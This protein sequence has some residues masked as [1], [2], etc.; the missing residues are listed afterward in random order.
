MKYKQFLFISILNLFS[1][2]LSDAQVI[3]PGLDAVVTLYGQSDGINPGTVAY[4]KSVGNQ[5]GAPHHANWVPPVITPPITNWTVD[6]LGQVFGIAIDDVGNVY[7]STTAMYWGGS[8]NA[9]RLATATPSASGA[10]GN[11]YH[12][13]GGAAG[14]YKADNTNLN[15]ISVLTGT[16]AVGGGTGTNTLPNTGFGIG[17]IAYA[18]TIDKLYASNLEDGIIYCIDPATGFIT[19]AFDPFAA[20]A[21]GAQIADFGERIFGLAVNN[22]TAETRLYYAVLMNDHQSDIWSVQLNA[23]TGAFVA[24][25]NSIEINLPVSSPGTY[26]SDLAF[27]YRGDL[28]VAEKGAPHNANVYQYFGKH[29]AWSLPMTL[30]MSAFT[31]GRNS[32]GGVDYGC[33]AK[34]PE[35]DN[36]EFFCDTLIWTQS[37]AISE[38]N[39]F[40]WLAYGLLSHPLN[41]YANPSDYLSEAYIVNLKGDVTQNGLTPK[42][43]F[44][45]VECY[46]WTCQPFNQDVCGM[47]NARLIKS[48]S[49]D[50]CYLLQVSNHYRADYFSKISIVSD[51]ISIGDVSKDSTNE[52]SNISYQSPTQLVFAK[53]IFFDGLPLDGANG[54]QT[55]G[56]L[57]FAGTGPGS[58]MINFIGN[59]PQNDTVCQ[60]IIAFEGCSVPVDTSCVSVLDIGAECLSGAISMKFRIRNNAAFTMRGLTLYSQTPNVLA[61]PKFLPIP[62][63]LP[64]ETSGYVET[65]LNITGNPSNACFFIAAC[66]QNTTPGIAGPYPN[67]CCMDSIPYCVEIPTCNPCEAIAFTTTQNDPVKCCYNIS[68]ES[69]YGQ[70]NLAYLEFIGVGGTQFAVFTGWSIVGGVSSSYVKIS[71]PGIGVSPGIY[72]DFASFCLTGTSVQPY[73]ILVNSLDSEGNKLCTNILQFE[74]CELVSPSC[75]QI[76]G[77]SLYCDGEK[78]RY[79]FYVKNNAD[80][81]IW[82]IDLHAAGIKLDFNHAELSEAILPDAT[83]GPFVF[84]VDSSD[85]AL[86]RFCL[87]LTA[88]NGI[89]DSINGLAATACC[90]DSLGGVCLPM[91]R[92]ETVCDTVICC[93]F[94]KMII[95]NGITPN[96]DGVNDAFVIVNASC[97]ASIA[98]TV[99]N[100]W[101][102]I[103][104][105]NKQYQ[106]DWKGE[107]QSNTKLAQGTYFILLE[108][109][110][111][112]KKAMYIDVRY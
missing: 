70:S 69:N 37:N 50:C 31:G 104:Y 4:V 34:S 67:W 1:C 59:L 22:E 56:T 47:V 76:V 86:D 16:V 14:I 25:T 38:P 80:F 52:W 10:G 72:P 89:Y 3:T 63:L 66:D 15:T 13:S 53:R 83:G 8:G 54:F 48:D 35:P 74:S 41:D 36:E 29:N 109:P 68:L 57:C 23:T 84:T 88:H 97:C 95:P 110:T 17:N 32:A 9:Q 103:V 98:M 12:I 107:N 102:N 92:C 20:D 44:G 79:S 19:D 2:I 61:S 75:A 85:K 21:S 60:K 108:L 45:D 112:N 28:L 49:G 43:S 77:D 27:S 93:D 40:T 24:A 101:G 65:T 111:G 90:T 64:G 96:A 7:F 81:P 55:L 18:K 73:T 46:D 94:S 71:A 11:G 5:L 6:H 100:Q 87:Y 58:L 30:Y 78:T 42:G 82:Q 99:Y 106:N 62:D 26:I 91:I 105:Q 39:V 51:Q 33:S